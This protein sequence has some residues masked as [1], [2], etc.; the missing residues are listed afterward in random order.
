VLG[1]PG[2]GQGPP[3]FNPLDSQWLYDKRLTIKA[4]GPASSAE[5]LRHNLGYLLGLMAAHRVDAR[6]L[7][8]KTIHWRELPELYAAMAADRGDLLTAVLQW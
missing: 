2:R 1:F 7:I 8:S 5:Q 6:R 4:A 3:D